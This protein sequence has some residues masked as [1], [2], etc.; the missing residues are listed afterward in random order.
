M[1]GQTAPE[2][3]SGQREDALLWAIRAFEGI[4]VDAEEILN[5]AK[6]FEA[7]VYGGDQ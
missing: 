7:Y 4:H 2:H 3:T 6:A 5:A 1:S